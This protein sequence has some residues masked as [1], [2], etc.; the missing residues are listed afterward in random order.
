MKLYIVRHGETEWNIIK[1]IQG[2]SNSN[3]TEKGI[4]DA[5]RLGERLKDIEFDYI[6]AS[7]QR[8]AVDTANI[9]KGKRH[10]EVIEIDDLREINHSL[11][12]GMYIDE[13]IEKYPEEYD[14]YMNRPHLYKPSAGESYEDLYHRVKKGLNKAI[15][16]GGEKVLI[17]THGVSLKIIMSMVKNIPLERLNEIPIYPGTALNIFQRRD[18]GLEL[19]LEGD[20]CHME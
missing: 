16:R 1:R 3:L 20:T 12:E 11:W 2:W 17:V 7:T 9:I 10:T 5:R 4:N 15:A 19:I 18:H 14:A 8:R 13:I 6:Y